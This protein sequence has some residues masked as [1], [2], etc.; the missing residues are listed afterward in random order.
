MP[1]P[2]NIHF[3]DVFCFRVKSADLLL[4]NLFPD[5]V[6]T[7]RETGQQRMPEKVPVQLGQLLSSRQIQDLSIHILSVSFKSGTVYTK[8]QTSGQNNPFC[9]VVLMC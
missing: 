6:T 1:Q 5:L 4:S 2:L 9:Q 8:L 7:P 3:S